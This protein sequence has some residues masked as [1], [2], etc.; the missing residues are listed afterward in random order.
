MTGWVGTLYL[1]G[2]FATAAVFFV[3]ALLVALSKKSTTYTKIWTGFCILLSGTTLCIILSSRVIGDPDVGA[4]VS[5]LAITGGATTM[6]AFLVF[7]L[8]FIGIL[9]RYRVIIYSVA[10]ITATLIVLFW[11]TSLVIGELER[12]PYGLNWPKAGPLM[13]LYGLYV[14]ACGLVPVGLFIRQ[15]RRETGRSR[16]Q[17]GYMLVALAIFG[18]A[19]V[20]T[21]MPMMQGDSFHALL[22]S[23]LSV[24]APSLITYAIIKHQLWDIRTVIHKTAL[25]TVASSLIL[26]PVYLLLRYIGPNL[27]L[28]GKTLAVAGTVVLLAMF[29][30]HFRLVQPWL[31]HLFARGRHDP[32]RVLEAFNQ[33][34][35]N[36]KGVK[37]VAHVLSET[38]KKTVYTS[39]V[40]FSV[41]EGAEQ[42]TD[43][44]EQT[45][46]IFTLSPSTRSWLTVYAAAVDAS[47]LESYD[48]LQEPEQCELERLFAQRGTEVAQPL[49]HE[50]ALIGLVELKEK[51]S[52][53]AYTRED[54]RIL[55]Q[56]GPAVTVA[57]A[58]A[59]LYDRLQ[60]LTESLDHRVQQRTLELQ[61]ANEKLLV[62]DRQK[63]KFFAN[64]THELR[65]PLTMVLA[66]LEDML[67]GGGAIKDDATVNELKVMHRNALRLL[68]QINALLDLARHDAGELRLKPTELRL[69]ALVQSAVRS[70]RPIARRKRITIEAAPFSGDDAIVADGEKLDL[71]LGNLLANAVKFTPDGGSILL[72]VR[73]LGANLR[74]AVRDSGIGIPQEHI[75]RIFDRFAQ[76]E[77]GTTRRFE[78]AGIGLSLVKELVELHCGRVAVTSEV[79]GGSEFSVLLPRDLERVP[80]R[81][82][83]RREVDLPTEHARRAADRDPVSW[84]PDTFEMQGEAWVSVDLPASDEAQP[85][86]PLSAEAHLLVVEDNPDMRDYLARS[87]GRRFEVTLASDG[88]AAL[89]RLARRLPDLVL[90]DV[91]MPE[92]SGYDLCRK[93]KADPRT[94][95][96]PVVLLT[97]RKGVD[98]TLEGFEAGADDYLTKPFN[99]QELLARI[100]V[101]LKLV[102]AGRRL[103]RH[104]K[105]EV[106]NLV[107]A[108]LAHEVRNPVNAILNASRLMIEEQMLAA[109]PAQEAEVGREL[110]DAILESAERI[111]LLCADLMGV[112]RPNLDEISDWQLDEALDAT[113]RLLKHKNNQIQIP[114]NRSFTHT[115]PLI[116]RTSQLNQVLMNLVDNAVRAA[117]PLGQIWVSTEQQR[118]TFRLRVRDDGPGIPDGMEERVFDPLYSAHA[119]EGARGL[120]LYISR[121]IV[122]DHN[123]SIKANSWQQGGEFVVELP[124]QAPVASIG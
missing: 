9:G 78:G 63:S 70:F 86:R 92:L 45:G 30:L 97:A 41:A 61:Q 90:A 72:S 4:V 122:E 46:V 58:N 18:V 114:V 98:R 8:A 77:S 75:E 99:N 13:P 28:G 10:P 2:L 88:K 110:L 102:E 123:G 69:Y 25:W 120:G 85:A 33:E 54:F 62:L 89:E 81:L 35:V 3:L 19:A 109:L 44:D 64:I 82:L 43:V 106:L 11:S 91:M 84:V 48:T 124:L 52:L 37:E 108:G 66:P 60:D 107:A 31:N 87:L 6:L 65:T 16:L 22:P 76:V 49:V 104:E 68:R 50:G 79:G 71:V 118:G 100:R 47:S 5:K 80:D 39:A 83:D 7:A 27:A 117:G 53:R 112:S 94:R 12:S 32:A 73:E 101:Q 121:Q 57:L 1:A 21:L 56:I 115:E 111:D 38:L 51:Q 42:F 15:Y 67:L 55:E 24:L 113:L 23:L 105:G 29:A 93:L 26:I 74:V 116:G 40:R 34:V 17:L 20:G 36:L 95:G 119:N 14:A 96:I 59:R 103:A